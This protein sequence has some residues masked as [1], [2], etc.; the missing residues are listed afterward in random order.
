MALTPN[1]IRPIAAKPFLEEICAAAIGGLR[2]PRQR[3]AY[4]IGWSGELSV[5]R[6]IPLGLGI[7]EALIAAFG[8]FDVGYVGV[9]LAA[10]D[11]GAVELRVESD[12]LPAEAGLPLKIMRGLANQLGAEILPGDGGEILGWRFHP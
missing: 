6:A 4:A 3:V 2:K 8:A 7:V 9:K 5:D 10:A 12:A 11:D 1:G